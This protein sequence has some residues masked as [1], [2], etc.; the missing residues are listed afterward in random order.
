M[1]LRHDTYRKRRRQLILGRNG[2]QF[3]VEVSLGWQPHENPDR[4]REIE[5]AVTEVITPRHR[6]S[7]TDAKK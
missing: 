6:R 4:E 5:D 1:V 2:S 3:G 7:Q